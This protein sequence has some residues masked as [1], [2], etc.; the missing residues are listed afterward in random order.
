MKRNLQNTR[1]ARRTRR[2][3][4]GAIGNNSKYAE[5][6]RRGEQMYGTGRSADGCCGHRIRTKSERMSLREVR[7]GQRGLDSYGNRE[8]E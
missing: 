1:E 5:K 4:A 3:T 7:E 8:Q 6:V 2:E